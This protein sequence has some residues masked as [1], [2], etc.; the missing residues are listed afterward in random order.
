M[1]QIKSKVP[2]AGGGVLK[3]KKLN[4]TTTPESSAFIGIIRTLHA[5]GVQKM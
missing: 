1:L 2:K 3:V 5:G 4:K